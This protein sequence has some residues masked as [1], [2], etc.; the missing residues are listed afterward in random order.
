MCSA[1]ALPPSEL[2][3]ELVRQLA[4]RFHTRGGRNE[5]RFHWWQTPTILPVRREGKLELLQWGSKSRYGPLP[6]GGW[7]SAD[8]IAAG[9]IAGASPEEVVIPANLGLQNGVWFVISVGIKG[10]VIRARHGST[11]Y[12]VIEPATNYYRNMTEQSP[13]MPVFVDQVI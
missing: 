8:H 2:P 5:I 3:D 6:Y 12:M 13:M 7:I 9:A 11:V 1:I 10:V 4:G